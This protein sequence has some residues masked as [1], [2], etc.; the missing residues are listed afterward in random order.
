MFAILFPVTETG[1]VIRGTAAGPASKI[2]TLRKSELFSGLNATELAVIARHS[3]LYA[4]AAG[5]PVFEQDGP[6]DA[7]FVIVGGVVRVSERGEDRKDQVIAEL[8]GGDTFGELDLLDSTTRNATATAAEESMILRFPGPHVRFESLLARHPAVGARLLFTSLQVV[9]GRIRRAN[10]LVKDNSPWVQELRRQVYGDSLTG[11]SNRTFLEE[12]LP[13]RLTDPARPAALLM[14]KPDN[15]K[16][17]NDTF[18]HEAGDATL[19]LVATTVRRGLGDG[20]L[21][22]RYM[23]NELAVVLPGFD[24]A[25]AA[26]RADDIRQAMRRLDLSAI[27][28]DSDLRLSMSVG[29]A[30][31]PEHGKDAGALIAA[32]HALPLLGRERGGNLV[33]FPEDAR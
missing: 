33:L 9:A 11:L 21:A 26:L 28:G 32:A 17:I 13:A 7:L 25:A 27:I 2:A 6:G 31:F 14:M 29:V 18:G 10:A 22:A 4:Y 5:E 24:R 23:G 1:K 3:R 30:V 8:V 16:E 15:F 19:R 12:N 20:E